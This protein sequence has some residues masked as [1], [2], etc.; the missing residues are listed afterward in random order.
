MECMGDKKGAGLMGVG[1]LEQSCL[2]DMR[3]MMKEPG[4]EAVTSKVET[5]CLLADLDLRE[6]LT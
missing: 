1:R 2:P 3:D 6:D 5:G 4:V